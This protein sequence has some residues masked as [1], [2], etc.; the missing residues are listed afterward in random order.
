MTQSEI[1]VAA[2]PSSADSFVSIGIFT[3]PA[4]VLRLRKLRLT[5][6]PDQTLASTSVRMGPVFRLIGSGIT[7]QS[8]HS[9]LGIFGGHFSLTD[10]GT[11]VNNATMEYD[12]DIPVRTGGTIDVQMKT[13]AEALAAGTMQANLFYDE[14]AAQSTNSMAD[15]V[16][17][18]GTLTADAYAALGTLT[19]PKSKEGNDPTK[20]KAIVIGVAIDEG[21]AAFSLR[22]A[23]RFRLTGSGIAEG[24]SHEIVGPSGD[25]GIVVIGGNAAYNLTAYIEVDIPVNPGGP[26]VVEQLFE[27]EV[28]TASSVAV[29]VLYA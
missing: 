3:V 19:V 18:V 29:G 5:C 7:E 25:F 26:I 13:L 12:V 22:L 20:I 1:K 14:N 4:G 6:A 16:D 8:P 24:G 11:A 2:V 27:N 21:I 17:A 23:S 10:E 9:Y 15:E 28:P